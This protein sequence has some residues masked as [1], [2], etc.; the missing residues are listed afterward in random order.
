MVSHFVKHDTI[1]MEPPSYYS[2]SAVLNIES[3][4]SLTYRD[5]ILTLILKSDTVV[6]IAVI[7]RE[8]IPI[9]LQYRG[10]GY[11]TVGNTARTEIF[12][13]STVQ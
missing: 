2:V 1:L 7:P 6:V 5:V 8:W 12:G 13:G 11:V 4:T 9:S 3:G 10:S